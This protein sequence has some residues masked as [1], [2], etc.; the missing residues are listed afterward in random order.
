MNRIFPHPNLITRNMKQIIRKVII[1]ETLNFITV[2]GLYLEFGVYS[3][4]SINY[5]SKHINNNYIYGFDSWQGLPEDWVF[6]DNVFKKGSYT[7]NGK[8]PSVNHNVKLVSGLFEDT[9]PIFVQQNNSPVAFMHIDS[10][11]YSSAKTIFKYLKNNIISGTVIL[12]DEY[13][14]DSGEE[15]AFL[16]FLEENKLY[17][18]A[19]RMTP[20]FPI[21]AISGQ[22]SFII[23]DGKSKLNTIDQKWLLEHVL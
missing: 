11:L 8:I 3:G 12:F 19:I 9:L 23:Y 21:N 15:Q 7:T 17:A 18:T 5:I 6:A 16:E 13:T 2:D 14:Y 20:K 10:D 22:A 4:T 1:K